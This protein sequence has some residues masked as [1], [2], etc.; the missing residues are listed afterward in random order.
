MTSN[1]TVA[2]SLDRPEDDPFGAKTGGFQK[3]RQDWRNY[4]ASCPIL[5]ASDLAVAIVID[6]HLNSRTG[7][8]FPSIK[9]IALLTNRTM[10]TVWKSINKLCKFGFLKKSIGGG[11]GHSNVYEPC[12]ENS[13][14]KHLRRGKKSSSKRK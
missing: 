12:W 8:A 13:E 2:G 6:N 14:A 1:G 5:S 3:A 10:A 7:Q 11:R 4:L 9:R